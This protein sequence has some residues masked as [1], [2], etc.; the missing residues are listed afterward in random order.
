MKFE[1]ATLA[2][3]PR[4]VAQC[5]DLSMILLRE[6]ALPF[7]RLWLTIALPACA[8]TFL[9]VRYF[10]ADLRLALLVFWFA[11]APCGILLVSAAAPSAFGESPTVRG[12]FRSLWRGSS[13]ILLLKVLASRVLAALLGALW[14]VPGFLWLVR[15]GF[16]SEQLILSQLEKELPDRRT[17]ELLKGEFLDL[18]FRAGI[19]WAYCLL[20][21]GVLFVT[22]D[23]LAWSLSFPILIGRIVQVLD[24]DY[25]QGTEILV[26]GITL[27]TSDSLTVTTLLGTAL[28]TYP[29]GRLAWMLCYID[30]RVRRDCWD[31]ELEIWHEARRLEGNQ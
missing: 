11:T 13:V 9:A 22:L 26:A 30:L 2:L 14:V 20:I 24:F 21:G 10:D 27:I 6:F 18:M 4:T 16:L 25:L 31:V 19:I 23:L 12:V 29:L 3:R 1:Q 8:G 7:L 17:K 15:T 5:L 28:A